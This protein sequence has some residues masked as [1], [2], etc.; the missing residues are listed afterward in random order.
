MEVIN[1]I[2]KESEGEYRAKRKDFLSSHALGDFRK[3]PE[4]FRKKETGEIKDEDSPAYALGRAAHCLILEGGEVFHQQ[5]LA[6]E[7]VNEKTGKAYGRNTLAYQEWLAEQKQ[8]VITPSDFDFIRRLQVSVWLHNEAAKLLQNGIAEGVVR[9]SYCGM[10]CQIRMDFFNPDFGIIDLKTCDEL[11]WFEADARRYGYIYQAAFY[12]A[13]LGNASGSIYPVYIVA[14]EKKQPFRCGVW[15]VSSTA[16][17]FAATENAA[18]IER[19]KKCRSENVW[20]TG[21]EDVRIME[22]I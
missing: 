19:L 12:R 11:T 21:Y 13:I 14:V 17:D 2:I 5:Y 10:P 9:E 15:C 6:G 4:F 7:P 8:E 18:A 3:C 22:S 20:P 16:L 1:C